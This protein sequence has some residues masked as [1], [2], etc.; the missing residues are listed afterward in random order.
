M[1]L[2][3][4]DGFSDKSDCRVVVEMMLSIMGSLAAKVKESSD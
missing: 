1:E 3:K 2:A 4:E